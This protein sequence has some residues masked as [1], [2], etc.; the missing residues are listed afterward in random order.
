[1]DRHGGVGP[2]QPQADLSSDR[3][4]AADGMIAATDD[5]NNRVVLIDPRT[6]RIVWQYGDKGSPRSRPGY[7]RNP[8][9]RDLVRER[10]G[11]RSAAGLDGGHVRHVPSAEDAAPRA[12]HALQIQVEKRDRHPL[13]DP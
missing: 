10:A 12:G 9:G 8:D 3:A 5:W 6:N 2:R 11:R 7:L 1:M 4:D 13:D